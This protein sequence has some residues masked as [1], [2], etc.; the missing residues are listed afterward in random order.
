MVTKY[1]TANNMLTAA[2]NMLTAANNML[3]AANNMLTAANNMLTSTNVCEHFINVYGNTSTGIRHIIC[4]TYY[5]R[6]LR[7]L[8]SVL[9]VYVH[10]YLL[11]KA[12]PL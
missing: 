9:Y 7:H 11:P 1:M 5:K 8:P 2:N 12:L 3:A 6:N 4:N 10:V